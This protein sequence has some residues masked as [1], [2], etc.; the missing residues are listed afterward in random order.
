MAGKNNISEAQLARSTGLP[1][2]TIHRLISGDTLDP[3]IST[4]QILADYFNVTLDYLVA[5]SPLLPESQMKLV[6]RNSQSLLPIIE[7]HNIAT[8]L[9]DSKQF[10]GKNSL[11]DWVPTELQLAENAFAVRS[12][13]CWKPNFET[14]TVIIIKP[15]TLVR[16]GNLALIHFIKE[17]EFSLRK[18]IIDG[19]TKFLEPINSY[20]DTEKFNENHNVKGVVIQYKYTFAE[21]TSSCELFV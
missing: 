13:S 18:L 21:T 1:Q 19:N 9:H 8:F 14:D 6:Q 5:K 11:T 15:T 7:W 4:L 10:L 20:N 2:P 16:D 3:R 17:N 12:R